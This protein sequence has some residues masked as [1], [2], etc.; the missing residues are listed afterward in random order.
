[1]IGFHP[2]EL[3]SAW[4][5]EFCKQYGLSVAPC[6]AYN[7]VFEPFNLIL[8]SF[9]LGL[10]M[11][12][13]R[14]AFRAF[15]EANDALDTVSS[16]QAVIKD[17]PQAP[18]T[19]LFSSL[20]QVYSST[21]LPFK[22][23]KLLDLVRDRWSKTEPER[24]EL[25]AKVP[26]PAARSIVVSGA[27]P[28]G[29]RS[30]IEACVLGMSVTVLERRTTF[31]R[32]NILKT[33]QGTVNDL[34]GWGLQIFYPNF[35]PHD[36]LLHLGTRE[37]QLVLLKVA[38]LVG[39]RVVYDRISC[40]ILVHQ[41]SHDVPATLL[42]LAPRAAKV[43]YDMYY[44]ETDT[45]ET[46]KELSLKPY[47]TNAEEHERRNLVDFFEPA[48]S[49][50]G[51]LI[52]DRDEL[53]KRLAAVGEAT[54]QGEEKEAEFPFV[55]LLI[56]EGERSRLIRHLGFD[57]KLVRYGPAVGIVVNLQVEPNTKALPE[58]CYSRGA[59]NWRTNVIGDL[60]K[61]GI[62]IENIEYMRGSSHFVAVTVLKQTLID[63]EVFKDKDSARSVH[64]S[65]VASNLDIGKLHALARQL[66]TSCGVPAQTPFA[67]INGVQIFDFSTKGCCSQQ[68]RLIHASGTPHAKALV[69]PIGDALQNPYWH[70][71]LGIN[72]GFHNS[73]DAVFATYRWLILRA[74]S[75]DDPLLPDATAKEERRVFFKLMDW[76]TFAPSSLTLK[77]W[78]ADPTTRYS[79]QL[80]KSLHFHEKERGIKPHT[81]PQWV[82]DKMKL[83]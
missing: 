42:A 59:S 67:A 25:M 23:K 52:P 56:A 30:A 81:L 17:I 16:F 37:M 9:T 82:M 7:S 4:E 18:N 80:F 78:K 74:D 47:E 45:L 36:H 19:F 77:D 58:F 35:R 29:L 24:L 38:L 49:S 54:T 3:G 43:Y 13:R 41:Q 73:L 1:M 27:G 8:S 10:V 51:A 69:L 70:Q 57:R 65:L 15:M 83:S 34:L 6:T 32:H 31:S 64:D 55:S 50:D 72:R 44:S 5:T 60:E 20:Y 21:D 62:V 48:K 75:A 40:G 61:R 28:C 11:S 68:L 53:Q 63:F 66:A 33:W 12:F 26:D 14:D 46:V 76:A 71:G 22:H 2:N 39:V 79:Y